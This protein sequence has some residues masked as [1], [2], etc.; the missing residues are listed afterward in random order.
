MNDEA[1]V[2]AAYLVNV[3]GLRHSTARMIMTPYP[4]DRILHAER[5][6]CEVFDV[7]NK[8]VSRV[9]QDTSAVLL[10]CK[11]CLDDNVT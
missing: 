7:A 2:L 5:R 11:L 8:H 10:A 4:H 1:R 3:E 9:G 6:D